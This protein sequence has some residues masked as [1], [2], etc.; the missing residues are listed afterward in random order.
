MYG[1][2]LRLWTELNAE[3]GWLG[4]PLTGE[5]GWRRGSTGGRLNRFELGQ[6]VCEN[7]TATTRE[8]RNSIIESYNR[9]GGIHSPLGLPLAREWKYVPHEFSRRR[10]ASFLG[11]PCDGDSD[12]TS[13][14]GR[15]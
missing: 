6:I 14:L 12:S 1:N 3:R 15:T 5:L 13:R 4:Y 9:L 2:L 10:P 11:S 8:F 7:G